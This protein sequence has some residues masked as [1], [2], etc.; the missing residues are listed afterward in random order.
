MTTFGAAI[1]LHLATKEQL[2]K[3]VELLADNKISLIFT[4]LIDFKPEDKANWE[5]LKVVTKLAQEKNMAVFADVNG[6]FFHDLDLV[7][8]KPKDLIIW[9]KKLGLS[10]VRFDEGI[11]L[12]LQGK[13][14]NNNSNFK[15][16]ING[17]QN[18]LNLDSLLLANKLNPKNTI[19]CYNF[20]PQRYTGAS[21]DFYLLNQYEAHINNI[22]F[23]SFVTLSGNKYFGPWKY[24]DNLPSLEIHRDWSITEQINH[25]IALGT[26]IIIIANQFVTLH[27]LIEINNIDRD[28][29]SLQITLDKNISN[30]EKIILLD[31]NIHV[32][33][34]DLAQDVIRSN[35][36]RNKYSDLKIPVR[37]INKEYLEI[38]DIVILNNDSQN[39]VCELQIITKRIKNDG[40]RNLVGKINE[41]Y[42]SYF[43]SELKATRPFKF[44]I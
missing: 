13:L 36:P 8:K 24:N 42:L 25:L 41:P 28:K 27:N 44:F 37:N 17:T 40:I 34:S 9:F 20:Y 33:R 1:Y 26:D 35:D 2:I 21:V 29:L 6:R 43:L 19:S 23:A 18:I 39:Y 5:K 11:S 4:T 10:G 30:E 38:G 14:T 32:V 12:Q 15:V 22:E 3:Y 16:L 31:E 7:Y